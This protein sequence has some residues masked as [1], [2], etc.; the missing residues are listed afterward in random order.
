VIQDGSP[1]DLSATGAR[2]LAPLVFPRAQVLAFRS[3]V[4]AALESQKTQTN[5]INNNRRLTVT[6]AHNLP[7]LSLALASITLF[8]AWAAPSQAGI[9]G[10]YNDRATWSAAAGNP[11]TTEAFSGGGLASGLTTSGTEFVSGGVLNAQALPT[12]FPTSSRDGLGFNPG[13]LALGGDW[14]LS[15]GGPGAGL[16]FSFTFA[17]ATTQDIFAISNPAGGGT[18]SGFFGFLSDTA[19]TSITFFTG[20]LTGNSELFTLDNLTF[21]SGG[22]GSGG[23]G[24]NGGTPVPEPASLA[25]LAGGLL[26][27]GWR[28]RRRTAHAK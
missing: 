8:A 1:F 3:F 17:D 23:D 13:T 28:L 26:M 24:G 20:S 2:R 16:G 18:F 27:S 25:L 12:V 5:P 21:G 10:T 4:G 22:N 11:A 19:I 6:H 7:R 9:I 15:P 14:D